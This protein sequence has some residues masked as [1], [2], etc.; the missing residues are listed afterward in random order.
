MYL[1]TRAH[2]TEFPESNESKQEDNCLSQK[3]PHEHHAHPGE[4]SIHFDNQL[5]NYPGI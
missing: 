3:G 1:V 2:Y 4:I 5:I